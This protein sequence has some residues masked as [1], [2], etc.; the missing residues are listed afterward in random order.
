M[1]PTMDNIIDFSHLIENV[2][3]RGVV[4][5]HNP[6]ECAV[7]V[8][9]E[10]PWHRA[11]LYMMLAGQ[12]HVEIAE[13]LGKSA[14]MVGILS[15]QGWFQQKS[16]AI[17]AASGGDEVTALIKGASKDCVIKLVELR[18]DEQTP[19]AVVA[20]VC[21]SL[22]D[23]YLGKAPQHLEVTQKGPGG[24]IQEQMEQV[25][26]ELAELRKHESTSNRN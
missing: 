21:N 12:S 1:K 5:L 23:R 25:E 22:L 20:T 26:R 3:G 9:T 10:K 16:A 2:E 4:P 19:K 13:A 8:Q 18:D 6:R 24:D 14:V 17:A 15:R 11:A 7:E